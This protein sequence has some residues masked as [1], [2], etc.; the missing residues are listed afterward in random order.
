MTLK[1]V[2]SKIKYID[3]FKTYQQVEFDE[4][5]IRKLFDDSDARVR[6]SVIDVIHSLLYTQYLYEGLN[7]SGSTGKVIKEIALLAQKKV[8]QIKDCIIRALSDKDPEVRIVAL[9]AIKSLQTVDFQNILVHSL[10]DQS[11][12]VRAKAV[13]MLGKLSPSYYFHELEE[14]LSDESNEVKIVVIAVLGQEICSDKLVDR[15]GAFLN[16]RN[17]DLQIASITALGLQYAQNYSR[18]VAGFLKNSNKSLVV[19]AINSLRYMEKI[20]DY[21]EDVLKCIESTDPLIRQAAVESLKD[22]KYS[23]YASK[24]ATLLSN[25]KNTNVIIACLQALREF[26]SIDFAEKVAEC[27]KSNDIWVLEEVVIT[28]RQFNAKEYAGK[29][30]QLYD[31]LPLIESKISFTH[32]KIV[33]RGRDMFNIRYANPRKEILKTL[34]YWGIKVDDSD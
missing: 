5:S 7:L 28:L 6:K 3:Y 12:I 21:K 32:H 24:I 4:Q 23:E 15:I 9:E 2:D 22:F 8:E 11:P 31:D 26:N 13:T 14:L 19:A 29:L 30:R 18:Q 25:D 10:K 20:S 16:S 1:D 27:L 33:N 17:Q 34:H